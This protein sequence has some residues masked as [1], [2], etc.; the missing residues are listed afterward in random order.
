MNN[1]TSLPAFGTYAVSCLVLCTLMLFIWVYS[2]AVRNQVKSTPNA[3]DAGRF[4]A[5]LADID[6]PTIARVLRAH[7]NAQ[8]SIVPFLLIGLIYVLVGGP[9]GAAQAYFGIFCV[10]RVLHAVTYLAALQP[11]R[12]LSFVVGFGALLGL[13]LHT[14][15][16][17]M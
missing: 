7:A 14:A 10:A 12:T 17:L 16:L 5:S 11:W 9:R 3:E 13:L 1:W 8:A 6:P 2:G 4:G 15:W